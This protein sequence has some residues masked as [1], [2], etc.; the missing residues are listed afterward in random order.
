MNKIT[1]N[2]RVSWVKLAKP[3]GK[4]GW[5]KVGVVSEIYFDAENDDVETAAVNTDDGYYSVPLADLSL[6]PEPQKTLEDELKAEIE[7]LKAERDKM[8]AVLEKIDKWADFMGGWEIQDDIH[9]VLGRKPCEEEP[10][11]KE[12]EQEQ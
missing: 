2:D 1:I 9:W 6:M 5:Q 8:K 10:P 12:E 3:G 4:A 11:E 7:E